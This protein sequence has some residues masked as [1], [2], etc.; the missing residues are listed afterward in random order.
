[1]KI[2]EFFVPVITLFFIVCS[3][4][5]RK[6]YKMS[7]ERFQKKMY[8][9]KSGDSWWRILSSLDGIGENVSFELS[10]SIL[11]TVHRNLK[12]GDT[13]LMYFDKRECFKIIWKF[14]RKYFLKIEKKNGRWRIYRDSLFLR[15]SLEV[16]EGSVKNHLWGSVLSIGERPELVVNLVNIFAWDIDFVSDVR[17]GDSFLILVEKYY[18]DTNFVRYGNIYYAKYKGIYAGEY[19]AFYFM[20]DYYDTLG[21]SLRKA[22]LKAP[23]DYIRIS[24]YFGMRFHP[25]LKVWRPHHGVDYA[26]PY[27]TPVQS[28]GDGRVIYAGWRGGYGKYVAIKHPNGY[29]SGYGHLSKIFVKVGQKVKQGQIIGKVGSTGLSTGPHLHFEIKYGNRFINPLKL[30]LPPAEPLPKKYLPQYFKYIKNI[31]EMLIYQ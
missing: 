12:I 27:G 8:I 15:K 2:K 4:Y 23:L 1:M 14:D 26:A 21:N 18:L 17:K 22:F 24:S 29:I 13:I 28:I 31:K 5:K 7:H 30:K 10:N 25:I 16:I 3:C 19:E 20:G 6:V 9:V 11:D